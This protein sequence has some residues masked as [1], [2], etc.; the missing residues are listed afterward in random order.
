MQTNSNLDPKPTAPPSPPKA[1]RWL[2]GIVTVTM[3][4]AIGIGYLS[5]RVVQQIRSFK[6][7]SARTQIAYQNLDHSYRFDEPGPGDS[8]DPER[9]EAYLLSR[10]R[11]NGCVTPEVAAKTDALLQG[12]WKSQDEGLL[13]I[14]SDSHHFMEEAT[15]R[16]LESLE[17]HQMS[18]K[19]YLWLHRY[20]IHQVLRAGEDSAAKDQL[21]ETAGMI[22]ASTQNTDASRGSF[23]TEDFLASLREE[24]A[25]RE[26][27]DAAVLQGWHDDSSLAALL[28][29]WTALPDFAQT[30]NLSDTESAA[31]VV[32]LES[33]VSNAP[34]EL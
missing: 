20:T 27:I 4:G 9:L 17:Y 22:E 2:L 14:V 26:P 28:D 16:H 30:M 1:N 18:P 13:R 21:M 34:Q 11:I 29:I 5:L 31:A 19:E 24:H 6:E 10:D 33:G 15:R 3:I 32:P 23:H 25:Q 12:N 7:F 8:V